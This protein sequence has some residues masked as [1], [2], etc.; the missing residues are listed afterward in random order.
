MGFPKSLVM[1]LVY[2]KVDRKTKKAMKY[3]C[4][5]SG[6][7]TG[8]MLTKTLPGFEPPQY[9]ANMHYARTGNC[10]TL[11]ADEEYYRQFPES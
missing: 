6:K 5:N 4:K 9:A 7:R 3:Y 1:K 8:K 2:N 11:L 10:I